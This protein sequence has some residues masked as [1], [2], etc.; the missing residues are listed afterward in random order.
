MS[1]AVSTTTTRGTRMLPTSP[2]PAR[3]ARLAVALLGALLALATSATAAHAAFGLESFGVTYST[4]QAG[5]H[6]DVKVAFLTNHTVTQNGAPEPD[7]QLKDVT[8]D[9]PPGVAGNPSAIA[10]CTDAQLTEDGPPAYYPGNCPAASQVGTVELTFIGY[11]DTVSF[12]QIRR[13]LLPVFNMVPTP[14]H[15]A[16]LAF[17]FAGYTTIPVTIDIRSDGDYGVR[18]SLR[19]LTNQMTIL[20]AE[21]TLW[22]NPSSPAHDGLRFPCISSANG[23]PSGTCP[24]ATPPLAFMTNPTQ[25]DTEL[26]A[27]IRVGSY[28]RDVAEAQTEPVKMTGCEGLRFEPEVSVAPTTSQPDAPTGLDVGIRVPQSDLAGRLATPNL[29]DVSIALPEGVAINPAGAD[30]LAGCT[31]AQ[32]G[33]GRTGDVSCPPASRIGS[34]EIDTPLLDDPLEG[35]VFV[36]TPASDDPASGRMFR[37][38]LAAHGSG[39]DVRLEGALVPDPVTGRLTATFKDNPQL[40]FSALN[41]RLDGGPR[42][43]LSTPM[44][45]GTATS[46]ATLRPWHGGE[47]V[48]STSQFAVSG[49]SCGPLPFAPAFSAGSA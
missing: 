4:T 24:A 28:Q 41:V 18:A 35:D 2:R 49:G 31:D 8:I 14:G 17:N 21:M 6:P 23:V 16:R 47:P 26:R 44:G 42:A 34:V 1:A 43:V 40:P 11:D 25:C 3:A 9:L 27:K 38:F 20:G 39:V 33:I 46:T 15:P 19:N 48:T 29:R 5:A 22:G 13:T 36:G 30:G 37:I 10:E 32:S 12:L 7:G 45:C